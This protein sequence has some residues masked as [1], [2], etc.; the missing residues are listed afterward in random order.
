[1]QKLTFLQES[2]QSWQ[3]HGDGHHTCA[4]VGKPLP[5]IA[6]CLTLAFK[7]QR[8]PLDGRR[9]T[10]VGLNT[11]PAHQ[12]F[13]LTCPVHAW[14]QPNEND[15]ACV[16]VYILPRPIHNLLTFS[17]SSQTWLIY[18]SVSHL[19]YIRGR[20]VT[21]ARARYYSLLCTVQTSSRPT[22]IYSL[23]V[24]WALSAGVRWD[25]RE[26]EPLISVKDGV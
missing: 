17:G 13:F 25:G 21:D 20:M 16:H 8:L 26:A 15:S 22:E 6:N 9:Y 23:S 18:L 11:T 2:P 24:P 10:A 7:L 5:S 4:L 1:M 19:Q 12:C 14:K 3:A